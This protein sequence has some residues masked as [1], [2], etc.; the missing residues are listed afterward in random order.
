VEQRKRAL[1]AESDKDQHH[2]DAG[3]AQ[4]PVAAD[5]LVKIQRTGGRHVEDDPSQQHHTGSH[6]D[7][8]VAHSGSVGALGAAGPDQEDGRDRGQLPIDEQRDQIARE[9]RTNRRP[10]VN[11]RRAVLHAI[12]HI[13]RVNRR[14]ERCNVEDVAEDQTQAIDP[15]HRQLV[16]EELYMEKG[17]RFEHEEL[18][19]PEH[20]KYH[21]GDRLRPSPQQ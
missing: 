13:Q 2:P 5:Q 15:D 3:R 20:R 7:D 8:H 6:L 11:H 19:E 17:P 21:R 12:T 4:Q 1:D 18:C 10:Y 16:I 9:H 14:Q